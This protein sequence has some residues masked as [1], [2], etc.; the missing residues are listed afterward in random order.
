MRALFWIFPSVLSIGK[1]GEMIKRTKREL[2]D[3]ASHMWRD[4]KVVGDLEDRTVM[5]L[6]RKKITFS[7]LIPMLTTYT[8]KADRASGH[9]MTENEVVSQ[10]RTTISAG[11]ETVSAIVSVSK[12]CHVL[13]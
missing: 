13:P 2:G 5:A 4:A 8:V 12:I 6:M 1:K 3:I 10:M 7:V 11:Y 9:S